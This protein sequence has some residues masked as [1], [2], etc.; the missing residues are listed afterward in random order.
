MLVDALDAQGLRYDIVTADEIRAGALNG[1]SA[2]IVPGGWAA[3]KLKKLSPG[4]ADAIRA[5]VS[6]G[7]SYF[8][9][10]GGAGL[11]TSDAL[12][13]INVTRR[14]LKER[15]PSLSGP[16]RLK[17]SPHPLW[18]GCGSSLF[19]IWW[20]SQFVPKDESLTTL[21][22]FE[23]HTE[24]T[25]SSDLCASDMQP[26]D[27]RRMEQSY[28]INLDPSRMQGEPLVIEGRYGEGRVIASLIHP[29]TPG[30]ANG[31]AMLKNAWSTMELAV[32]APVRKRPVEHDS[33]LVDIMTELDDFGKR[34]FLWYY[35][36]PLIQWRRG[37]RGTEYHTLH[38]MARRI[39]DAPVA[40][41]GEVADFVLKARRLLMHE[42]MALQGGEALSFATTHDELLRALRTE[43]FA[44]SKSYG[45]RFKAIL[46][47][48]DALV[49]EGLRK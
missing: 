26:E 3:N 27:W 31:A 12:G 41:V 22:A 7:G 28:G 10:C 13:L 15:T 37:I 45:G 18:E 44:D 43:L 34:N 46:D 1:Y 19:N 49:L 21:A 20:P 2:L 24:G 47:K 14:P 36:S 6:R 32:D 38:V 48:L 4:G 9:I 40:L 16:V 42:R 17:L 11:A 5:F 35:R 29:D 8:G 30:D 25:Y 23:S 33:P 39:C